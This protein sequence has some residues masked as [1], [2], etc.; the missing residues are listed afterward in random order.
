MNPKVDAYLT[1]VPKWQKELTALRGIILE[2]GLTEELKWST[3]VYTFNGKNVIALNALKEYCALGFFKGALLSDSES[4]LSRVS[5]HTQGVR[6][7]RFT[8]VHEIVRLRAILTA[9]IFEAVEVEKSGLQLDFQ[10]RVALDVPEELKTQFKKL[11]KLKKA[12]TAL[13]PGRQRAYLMYFNSAKQ[14]KTRTDRIA[15]NIPRILKG[16]GLNDYH[17]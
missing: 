13:T 17:K 3:P 7:V 5:E 8:D 1:K 9:Y 16:Q 4:I 11:P 14:S 15:K 12:F 6:L 10:D 2:C